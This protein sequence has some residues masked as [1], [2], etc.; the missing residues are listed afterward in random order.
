MLRESQNHVHDAVA[1]FVAVLDLQRQVDAECQI[2]LALASLPASDDEIGWDDEF[3]VE[4]GAP[5][6]P[7]ECWPGVPQLTNWHRWL[8]DRP[9][10]YPDN[11]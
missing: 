10:D 7:A 8:R 4:C 5:L 6:V 2:M 9:S 11:F 1:A 3:H